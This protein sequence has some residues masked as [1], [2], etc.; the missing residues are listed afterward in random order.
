MKAQQIGGGKKMSRYQELRDNAIAELTRLLGLVDEAEL[1]TLI[2]EFDRSSRIFVLGAG[3]SGLAVRGYAMRLMHLGFPVHVVGDATTPSIQSGE[4]LFAVSGSGTTRSVVQV[5]ETA[6]RIGARLACMTA[7][8]RSP[9]AE[10]ADCCLVVPA[11]TPKAAANGDTKTVRSSQP[12]ASL[13]EQGV[14][15][16]CD[17]QIALLKERLGESEDSM[18]AR[19]ANLE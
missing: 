10:M 15:L 1:Q 2:D 14:S 16:L 11:S 9:L 3:R 6:K 12:L 5:A 17:L 19:H 4:L 18:M 8:R 13:F 7:V